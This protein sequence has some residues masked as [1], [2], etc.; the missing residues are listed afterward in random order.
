MKK[1]FFIFIFLTISFFCQSQE[2]PAFDAKCG[3]NLV[4]VSADYNFS[5]NAV[6]NDFFN[7]FAFSNFIDDNVKNRVY[8]KLKTQN[9]LEASNNYSITFLHPISKKSLHLYISLEEHQLLTAAFSDDFFKLF[10]SGNK[11]FAGQNLALNNIQVNYQK[12]EQ[13]KIGLVKTLCCGSNI[14]IFGGSASIINGSDNFSGK[15]STGN[16]FTETNGEYIDLNINSHFQ[17][18]DTLNNHRM[19]SFNGIGCSVELFYLLKNNKGNM[20]RIALNNIGFIR[21]NKHSFDTEQNK[22]YHFDGF[23]I[24]NILDYKN[25]NFVKAKTDSMSNELIYAKEKSYYTLTPIHLGISY[26]N[27]FKPNKFNVTFGFDSR[28]YV[29]NYAI[30]YIKPE[31]ILKTKYS[32]SP[33]FSYNS[34][35]HFNAGIDLT[36]HLWND[37]KISAKTFYL[38]G[39]I[40]SEK[41]YGQGFLITVSKT[42]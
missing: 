16:L 28:F 40:S 7:H 37:Y 35:N 11:Q 1:L 17:R 33:V 21:W 15:I 32:V 38:N 3:K 27:V 13:L 26:T 22:F 4:Q 24:D 34:Y 8:E 2:T 36:M 41:T 39:Y 18:T 5:S 42:F 14:Q 30:L 19:I 23:Y 9:S 6:T 20:F 10:F 12:F 31:F 29:L 25:T